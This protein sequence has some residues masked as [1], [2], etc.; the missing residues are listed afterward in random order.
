MRCFAASVDAVHDDSTVIAVVFDIASTLNLKVGVALPASAAPPTKRQFDEQRKFG[1][2]GW[3]GDMHCRTV[4]L[5]L[6]YGEVALV[7]EQL[8]ISPDN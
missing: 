1:S 7:L 4:V 5:E 3:F 8:L 6:W 2:F